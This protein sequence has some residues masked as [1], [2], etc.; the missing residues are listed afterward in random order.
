MYDDFDTEP[1]GGGNPYSR[2]VHCKI[3]VPQINYSLEGHADWCDYRKRKESS[4]NFDEIIKHLQKDKKDLL[5]QINFKENEIIKEARKYEIKCRSCRSFF[6]LGDVELAVWKKYYVE[7]F[8]CTDGDYYNDS[9]D[10]RILCPKCDQE[11]RFTKYEPM[12][13][14]GYL[15][16]IHESYVKFSNVFKNIGID[17]GR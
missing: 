1:I 13:K 5:S 11:H 14:E 17:H 12:R 2:C 3:S 16:D 7:P 9:N 4:R 8:G 6:A 10:I 15:S